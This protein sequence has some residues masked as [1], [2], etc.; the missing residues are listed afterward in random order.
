M[1]YKIEDNKIIIEKN[2]DFNPEH[3]LECGQVFRFGKIDN[4]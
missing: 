4:K 1:N 3:I 2:E